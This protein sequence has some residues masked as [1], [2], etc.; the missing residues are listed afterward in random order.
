M[1]LVYPGISVLMRACFPNQVLRCAL[2]AL[3]LVL[4][5]QP[6]TGI[7]ASPFVK[8]LQAQARD[9]IRLLQDEKRSRS[10]FQQKL[11]SQL[12][13]AL[14]QKRFGVVLPGVSG[15]RPRLPLE[16]SGLLLVD[17]QAQVTK[18]HVEQSF[19]REPRPER[20]AWTLVNVFA[21]TRH[22]DRL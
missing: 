22:A 16:P 17:L 15:L 3:V 12:V 4:G 14:R 6:Q 1:K 8:D 2:V 9:Q 10:W 5:A 20:L 19:V 7:A 13:Y 18:A 11:D 21:M